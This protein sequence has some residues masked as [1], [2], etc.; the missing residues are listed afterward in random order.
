M[1]IFRRSSAL[2]QRLAVG[3]PAKATA[4]IIAPS[5]YA[6]AAAAPRDFC[7]AFLWR[8]SLPT[9][10]SVLSS[11]G[12][13]LLAEVFSLVFSWGISAILLYCFSSSSQVATS[14]SLKDPDLYSNVGSADW[15]RPALTPAKVVL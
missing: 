13:L 9:P 2:G 7:L 6:A 5:G 15:Q 12:R 1:N 4:F 14:I 8:Q 11:L 10:L 3:P